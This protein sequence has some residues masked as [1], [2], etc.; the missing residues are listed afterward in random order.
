M[1][2]GEQ[3]LLGKFSLGDPALPL[4]VLS[5]P[6]AATWENC[7]SARQTGWIWWFVVSRE[8]GV[9]QGDESR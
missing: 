4:T 5:F 1:G 3:E 7:H 6:N 2:A 9:S 8:V